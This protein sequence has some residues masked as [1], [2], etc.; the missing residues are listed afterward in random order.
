MITGYNYLTLTLLRFE[1][2]S[3]VN[4][5]AGGGGVLSVTN[6]NSGVESQ[7]ASWSLADFRPSQRLYDD[8]VSSDRWQQ[9]QQGTGQ[10]NMWTSYLPGA[11][12]VV[13]LIRS[14]TQLPTYLT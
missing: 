5:Y 6:P 13:R 3:F 7:T 14:G 2:L 10:P 11:S 12:G 8:P 1:N 4:L 9:Q